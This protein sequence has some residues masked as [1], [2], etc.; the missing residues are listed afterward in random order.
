MYADKEYCGTA[1]GML[2]DLEGPVEITSQSSCSSLERVSVF[3]VTIPEG[4]SLCHSCRVKFVSMCRPDALALFALHVSLVPVASTHEYAASLNLASVERWISDVGAPRDERAERLLESVKRYQ[5]NR[6]SVAGDLQQM[7]SQA[8]ANPRGQHEAG[9]GGMMQLLSGMNLA[10]LAGGE[11]SSPGTGKLASSL[12]SL[13]P[14]LKPMLAAMAPKP[15]AHGSGESPPAVVEDTA[16][17]VGE[18]SAPDDDGQLC[19]KY[20]RQSDLVALEARLKQHIDLRFEAMQKFLQL[21]FQSIQQM[22]TSSFQTT[23]GSVA[24]DV[25]QASMSECGLPGG[26]PITSRPLAANALPDSVSMLTQA[27]RATA[28]SAQLTLPAAAEA[29]ASDGPRNEA[30]L[31]S[32]MGMFRGMRPSPENSGVDVQAPVTSDDPD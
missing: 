10:S 24:S 19:A 23:A 1:K 2:E 22:M 25:K 16:E 7:M 32:L 30:M 20:A 5:D 6:S 13:L 14:H 4:N 27:M 8:A 21:Q 11:S 15:E 31:Q 29:P 18:T 28:G 26:A 17:R 3:L 9:L 12:G